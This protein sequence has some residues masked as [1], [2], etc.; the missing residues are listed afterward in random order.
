MF[1]LLNIETLQD[2]LQNLPVNTTHKLTFKVVFTIKDVPDSFTGIVFENASG[3]LKL[4]HFNNPK[5]NKRKIITLKNKLAPGS[6][7]HIEQCLFEKCRGNNIDY[8]QQLEIITNRPA[9][10]PGR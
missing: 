8:P 3:E 6:F 1:V 10:K 2:D 7:K 9:R 5:G 4:E